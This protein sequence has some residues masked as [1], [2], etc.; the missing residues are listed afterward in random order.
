MEL[1]LTRDVKDNKVFCKTLIAKVRFGKMWVCCWR[2]CEAWLHRTVKRLRCQMPSL[3]Q[4]LLGRLESQIP[5]TRSKALNKRDVVSVEEDQI[6][7]YFSKLSV[8]KPMVS[9][10]MQYKCWGSWQ[11]WFWGCCQK[12][13]N[14]HGDHGKHILEG[15]MQWGQNQALS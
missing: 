11:I 5:E 13:L 2:N 4:S 12:S 14:D 15:S 9:N 8:L 6:R 3:P 10:R 7:E 1:N